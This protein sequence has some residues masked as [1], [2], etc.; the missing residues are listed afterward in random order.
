MNETYD[1]KDP[2]GYLHPLYLRAKEWFDSISPQLKEQWDMYMANDAYQR[3]REKLGYAHLSY[4]MIHVAIEAIQ[5]TVYRILQSEQNLHVYEAT[6]QNDVFSKIAAE[7]LTSGFANIRA[8]LDY[9][10]K[11]M[12]MVL[13]SSIFDF[14]HMK[15]DTQVL[16]VEPGLGL[17]LDSEDMGMQ[18]TYPSWEMLAPGR[19][20]FDGSYESDEKITARFQESFVSYQELKSD[21]PE[22]VGTW[23]LN[24]ERPLDEV[25]YS[26]HGNMGSMSD[27][28]I[29]TFYRNRMGQSSAG[30]DQRRG[31]LLVQAFAKVIYPDGKPGNR[32]VWWLPHVIPNKQYEGVHKF[33]Y[34]LADQRP[35][36]RSI[37]QPFRTCRSRRLPFTVNG[38][39]TAGLL[40]PFQRQFS[41]QI[42]QEM[43]MDQLY[44]SPP[45]LMREGVWI[46]REDPAFNA[47]EIWTVTDPSE[48]TKPLPLEQLVRTMDLPQRNRQYLDN[49]DQKLQ[50]MGDLISAAVEATTGAETSDTNKTLGA[51]QGRSNGAMNRIMVQ[52]VEHAKNLIWMNTQTVR[53]MR[54]APLE[55]LYPPHATY[56]QTLG[57]PGIIT[58]RML[59][60][61]V[62][63]RV[64][65]LSEYAGK[66]LHKVMWRMVGDGLQGLSVFN[67]SPEFQLWYAERLIRSM[68]I[69][70]SEVQTAMIAAKDGIMQ[71]AM[72]AMAG[73]LA[74]KIGG[75][76][77]GGPPP[78]GVNPNQVVNAGNM[79][80]ALAAA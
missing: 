63:V 61:A 75:G 71:A 40:I 47:R 36:F 13:S 9:D 37:G 32:V 65:A 67:E 77:R 10:S 30:K 50:S 1:R 8:D 12:D 73:S 39:G 48:S 25:E 53:M 14:V 80:P 21:W 62:R 68:G 22:Q 4:P 27:E 42:A 70:E 2:L 26:A 41:A 76:G 18:K 51:F 66:E 60:A 3:D 45:V 56:S 38:R 74:P 6:D 79:R 54:E 59:Q 44:Q 34:V 7:H 64:P 16:P 20:L 69:S 23:L 5:S 31:F 49:M 17:V 55:F 43:D 29:Y 35:A 24:H 11:I 72:A 28:S 78:P 52:F 33:G 46:G 19:V 15:L 57:S 58:P